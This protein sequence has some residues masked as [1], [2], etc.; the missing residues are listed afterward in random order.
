MLNVFSWGYWGWGTSTR[1]LVHVADTVEASRG[2]EPPV[3]VDVRLRRTVRAKGFCGTAF[4]NLLGDDRYHHFQ[5]LGNLRI[6]TG[7]SGITI[8]NP[9]AANDLFEVVLHCCRESRR[10]IFFCACEYPHGSRGRCHRTQVARLLLNEAKRRDRRLQVV[11]WPGGKPSSQKLLVSP[12]VFQTVAAGA[13]KNIPIGS[14]F[15]PMGCL[16]WGSVL[17][18]LSHED[19][20]HVITGPAKYR[21]NKW[22][23]PVLEVC[24]ST[25]KSALARESQR[26]RTMYGLDERQV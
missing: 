21:D 13:R 6:A 20:V 7:G 12:S 1:K 16:S 14:K 23:V 11:E 26:I 19:S 5:D 22:A 9:A 25:E 3:F 2:F 17:Q 24:V 18:L 15:G 4:E 10:V 8:K